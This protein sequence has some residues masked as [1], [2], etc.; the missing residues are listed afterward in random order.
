M[1]ALLLAPVHQIPRRPDLGVDLAGQLAHLLPDAALPRV[2][3]GP[4]LA[5]VGPRAG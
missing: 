4:G 2:A 5:V 1:P 3:A